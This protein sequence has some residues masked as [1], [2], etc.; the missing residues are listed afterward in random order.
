MRIILG[1]IRELTILLVQEKEKLELE[2]NELQEEISRIQ[3]YA[4]NGCDIDEDKEKAQR[5]LTS[6]KLKMLKCNRIMNANC[7]YLDELLVFMSEK[8]ETKGK[9]IPI[10]GG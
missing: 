1:V 5:H 9:V 7:T 8:A 10:R 4:E 2:V 3:F 6:I